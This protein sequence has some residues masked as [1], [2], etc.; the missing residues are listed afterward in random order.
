MLQNLPIM[1]FGISP[2]FCLLCLFLCFLDMDTHIHFFVEISDRDVNERTTNIKIA[3]CCCL[4]CHSWQH[5]CVNGWSFGFYYLIHCYL[6]ASII[7]SEYKSW[8]TFNAAVG[9][10]RSAMPRAIRHTSRY[11]NS[12]PK[13]KAFI[14][15]SVADC[16]A[17]WCSTYLL[18]LTLKTGQSFVIRVL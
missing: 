7:Q 14:S 17:V 10:D 1:L 3:E 9:L 8:S 15:S 6:T 11:K 4:Q 13:L 5:N 2:I 18:H 12:N 16:N